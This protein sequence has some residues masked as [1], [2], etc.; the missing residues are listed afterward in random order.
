[1]QGKKLVERFK[2]GTRRSER[3][4]RKAAPKKTAKPAPNLGSHS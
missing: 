2:G 4:A 3:V 1:L